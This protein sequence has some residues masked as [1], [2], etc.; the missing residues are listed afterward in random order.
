MEASKIKGFSLMEAFGYR[1][2]DGG[3][4]FLDPASFGLHRGRGG[5]IWHYS[6]PGFQVL[7]KVT[8]PTPIVW[9]AVEM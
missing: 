1:G 4:Q 9:N 6:Q 3:F 2:S 8:Q 5:P 7:N